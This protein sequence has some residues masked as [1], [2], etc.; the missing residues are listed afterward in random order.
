MLQQVEE[1]VE[2]QDTMRDGKDYVGPRPEED[3][4]E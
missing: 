2:A 1:I 4:G 3:I